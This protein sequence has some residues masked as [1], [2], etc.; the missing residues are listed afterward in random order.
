MAIA[1]KHDDGSGGVGLLCLTYSEAYRQ[2]RRPEGLS[3]YII[4]LGC[5]H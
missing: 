5:F 1:H 4:W 2:L 3:V